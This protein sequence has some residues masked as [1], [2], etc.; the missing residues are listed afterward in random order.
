MRLKPLP[1]SKSEEPSANE[2]RPA[3]TLVAAFHPKQAIRKCHLDRG[4][5][6]APPDCCARLAVGEWTRTIALIAFGYAV[7]LRGMRQSEP[8]IVPDGG[9]WRSVATDNDRERLRDWRTLLPRRSRR[10]APAGMGRESPPRGALL[11]PDA[12]LPGP[13]ITN[14]DIAAG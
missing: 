9:D 14:G 8:V 5:P 6:V 10:R 11:E 12:A 3:I 13:A 2:T 7:R 4:N 1:L